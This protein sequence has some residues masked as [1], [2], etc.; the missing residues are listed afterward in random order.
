MPNDK[1]IISTKDFVKCIEHK[2]LKK[3]RTLVHVA[4]VGQ[5]AS[6]I[7]FPFPSSMKK[8]HHIPID[9]KPYK[10]SIL[11]LCL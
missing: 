10:L 1:Q 11:V 9:E 8:A 2:T 4:C 6:S 5:L 3:L 7:T